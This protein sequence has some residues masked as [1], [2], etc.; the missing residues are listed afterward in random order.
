MTS[1]VTLWADGCGIRKLPRH[2]PNIS[3]FWFRK[4]KITN[5]MHIEEI[6]SSSTDKKSFYFPNNR[7]NMIPSEIKYVKNLEYLVLNNNQ[8]TSLPKDI[9]N[10]TN[11]TQLILENNQF[12]SS[13]R[14]NIIKQFNKSNPN[15]QL[16]I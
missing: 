8:L 14:Q 3:T 4:N 2:L 13:E 11:L 5:L 7:I 12:S 1:L 6:G 9:Y 16:I 10:L 15:L